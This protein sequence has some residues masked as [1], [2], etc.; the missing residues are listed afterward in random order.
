MIISGLNDYLQWANT[1]FLVF[2]FTTLKGPTPSLKKI[3]IIPGT[4]EW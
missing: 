4:K 3:E 2:P 1:I